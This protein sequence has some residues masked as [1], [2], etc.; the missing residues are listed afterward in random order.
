[1]PHPERVVDPEA[2]GIDG[3]HFFTSIVAHMAG[4]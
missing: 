4:V 3:Q 1:M 2:N